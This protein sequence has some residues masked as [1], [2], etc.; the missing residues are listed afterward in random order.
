MS[1]HTCLFV[2]L[3]PYRLLFEFL[4][5]FYFFVETVGPNGPLPLEETIFIFDGLD[6]VGNIER[7]GQDAAGGFDP[8][9]VETHQVDDKARDEGIELVEQPTDRVAS[10]A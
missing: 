4:Y 5:M 6:K 2:R 8:K 1:I 10:L 9:P 7:R 3:T